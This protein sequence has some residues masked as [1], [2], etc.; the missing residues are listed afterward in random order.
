M[1]LYGEAEVFKELVCRI[2]VV[3][4]I[5]IYVYA[6]ELTHLFN[7]LAIFRAGSLQDCS[8]G[9]IRRYPNPSKMFQ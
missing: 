5:L 1:S 7:L 8:Q 6:N 9:D 3:E 2:H 4:A